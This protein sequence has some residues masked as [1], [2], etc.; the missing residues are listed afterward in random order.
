RRLLAWLA[1]RGDA[2]DGAGDAAAP[3]ADRGRAPSLANLAH[4]LQTGREAMD[5]RLALLVDGLDALR[6]GLQRFLGMPAGTADLA[7]YHGNVQDQLEMRNLLSG[8]AGDA[9]AQAL[10]AERNLE[11]LM[12]HWVQG[13]NVPWLA[14][15]EGRPARRIVLPTYPFER[16]RY[17]LS[18]T[19][20]GEADADAAREPD[21]VDGRA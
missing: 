10:A 18:G 12:L 11:G 6:D 1:T 15:R 16:A 3:L 19:A 7:M 17:W 8:A 13:G 20:L 2:A 21:V 4:T 9:M 14:L 5:C